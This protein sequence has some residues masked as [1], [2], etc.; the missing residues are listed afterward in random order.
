MPDLLLITSSAR[1]SSAVGK[2]MPSVLAVFR[3]MIN[4]TLGRSAGFAPPRTRPVY[5]PARA[6]LTVVVRMS[7]RPPNL[8]VLP[9]HRRIIPGR[10]AATCGNK[11]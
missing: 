1:T 3:L 8:C 2:V 10:A 5:T 6:A 4:S 9:S 11:Q 7:R